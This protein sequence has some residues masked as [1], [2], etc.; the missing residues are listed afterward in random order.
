VFGKV[1]RGMETVN[2]IKGVKTGSSGMH[3][4]VPLEPVVIQSIS[5]VGK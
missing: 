4:D 1:I 3:R 2:A 5:R